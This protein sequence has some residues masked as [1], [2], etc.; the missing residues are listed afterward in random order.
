M[1]RMLTARTISLRTTNI[2]SVSEALQGG[3]HGLLSEYLS[4]TA[5]NFTLPRYPQKE[6][7]CVFWRTNSAR[8]EFLLSEGARMAGRTA[9][10]KKNIGALLGIP[11]RPRLTSPH[12]LRRNTRCT[13]RCDVEGVAARNCKTSM[14]CGSLS[15][16]EL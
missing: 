5:E 7:V 12:N 3:V 16:Q 6:K 15:Q 4:E 10:T 2:A 8:Q 9:D 11:I 13:C 1:N 14:W